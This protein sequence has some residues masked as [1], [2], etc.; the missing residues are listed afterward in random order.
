MFKET[1]LNN[2]KDRRD[3]LRDDIKELYIRLKDYQPGTVF[4]NGKYVYVKYYE[5]GK[6]ISKYIGSNLSDNEIENLRRSTKNHKTILYRIKEE[7]KELK[8]I[9][10]LISRYGRKK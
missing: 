5:N 9:E 3:E 8:E 7:S 1:L 2:F 4:I 10:K 6:T